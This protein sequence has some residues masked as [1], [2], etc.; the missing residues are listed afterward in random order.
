MISVGV[1]V[2]LQ[3]KIKMLLQIKLRDAKWLKTFMKVISVE[4]DFTK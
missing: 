2:F 4:I 1:V 3:F